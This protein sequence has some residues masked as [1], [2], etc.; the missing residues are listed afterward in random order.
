[1]RNFIIS[2]FCLL[3]VVAAWTCFD[4]YAS[5]KTDLYESELNTLIEEY[6]DKENWD[7]AYK[8]FDD[9]QNDWNRYKKTASFFLDANDLNHIDST[10]K[11]THYYISADDRSNSS[12]ELA[13]LIG[14][15][16]ALD[17]NEEITLGNVF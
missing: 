4:I 12:G 8:K 6:V 10:F 15:F 7:E 9:I 1:M 14:L 13:Y 3:A 2:M 16:K 17:K 5:D 11:K